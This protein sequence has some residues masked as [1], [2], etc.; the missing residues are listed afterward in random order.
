[1]CNNIGYC[2]LCTYIKFQATGDDKGRT[3]CTENEQ[4]VLTKCNYLRII[5]AKE[6]ASGSSNM[7]YTCKWKLIIILS[8][9]TQSIHMSGRPCQQQLPLQYR[10]SKRVGAAVRVEWVVRDNHPLKTLITKW[11]R[12]TN[13]NPSRY[14]KK[15]LKIKPTEKR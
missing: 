1:M 3:P 4:Q 12:P 14:Q 8:I 11:P 6:G 15:D 10:W 13:N 9:N 7:H 5:H 2:L